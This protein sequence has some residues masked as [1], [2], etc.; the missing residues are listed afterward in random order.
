VAELLRGL[1]SP[2]LMSERDDDIIEFDFFDDAETQQSTQRRPAVRSRG[3]GPP[4]RPQLRAPQGFTPLLRLVLLIALAIFVVVVLVF[5]IQSCRNES[6]EN[7]YRDY[8]GEMNRV[9]DSSAA[10]GN[11]LNDQLT[12]PGIK[13]EDLIRA[14]EGLA[15]RQRQVVANAERIDAPG[16]LRDEHAASIEALQF[17]INGLTGLAGAFERTATSRDAGAAGTLLATQAERFVASDVIWDDLFVEPSKTELESQGITG[18]AVPDSNFIITADLASE[19]SMTAV[20][21]RLNEAAE[22]GTPTGLHGTGIIS[23]TVL[24]VG[25]DLTEGEETVVEA[26]SDLAFRVTI[27]NSGESQEVGIK[28]T[29]TIQKSPE[30]ITQTKTIQLI[31]SGEQKSVTFEDLGQPTFGATTPVKV[32]VEPVP[33]EARTQ[34]NSAEY[35]V[36][37][38]LPR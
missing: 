33:G 37:F 24:P 34:N 22:G 16:P 10:I 28:V 30:P 17:R 12:T 13:E 8:M 15:S 23:T 9:A 29:L 32:D 5:W 7:A 31:N 38:A 11:D 26:G 36:V 25:E 2:T 14:I 1:E 6:R 18:V 35:P 4:R 27:E 21:R 3:G 19:R 20:W